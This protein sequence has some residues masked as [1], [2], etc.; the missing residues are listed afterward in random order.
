[1]RGSGRRFEHGLLLL[2]FAPAVLGT[3]ESL[4]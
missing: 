4:E 1:M 2:L 3:R